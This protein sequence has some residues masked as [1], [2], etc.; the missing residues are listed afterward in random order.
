MTMTDSSHAP[1]FDTGPLSWV[2]SEI[3]D[4]LD[5]SKTALQEAAA[6]SDEAQATRPKSGRRANGFVPP[7]FVTVMSKPTLLINP[8]W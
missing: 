5:R 4:A 6:R 2:M 8:R 3:R 1:Q 7:A